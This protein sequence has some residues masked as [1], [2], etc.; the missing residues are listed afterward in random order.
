MAGQ[1]L[2]DHVGVALGERVDDPRA[3]QRRQVRRQPGQPLGLGGQLDDLHAQRRAPQRAAVRAVDADLLGDVGHHAVVRRRRRPQH[4]DAVGQRREHVRQPP[5][6]GPEV[7]P[8][9]GDA[10]RLVD[11]QQPDARREQRQH[12]VAEL[13]VVEP[14]GRDQQQVDGVVGEHAPHRVPLVAVGRV[15]GVRADAEPLGGGDLVAHQR[16]QRRDDQRRPGAALAQQ[17]GGDEVHGGLA[18]A[19]ALHAQHARPV[20]NQVGDRLALVGAEARFRP[21]Q[22]DQQLIGVHSHEHVRRCVVFFAPSSG[23]PSC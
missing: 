5:V 22:P 21:R 17:R 18:P 6:V 9:V 10:V 1:E 7:V 4:C 8:P 3:R 16:Q 15:D 12:L 2:G 20:V 14:L 19:R 23:D 13:R 11:H